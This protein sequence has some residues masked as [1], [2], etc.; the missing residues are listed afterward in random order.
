MD[1]RDHRANGVEEGHIKAILTVAGEGDE[2]DM[3]ISMVYRLEKVNVR[4]PRSLAKIFGTVICIGGAMTMAFFKGPKLLSDINILLDS[5][6][7]ISRWVMGALFLVGSS[8]CWSL[9]LILQV[10]ICKSYVEPLTLSA[11][12]CLLSTL[13]SALLVSFLLPDPAAWRIHSLFELSCCLFAVGVSSLFP[14]LPL[15]SIVMLG[16]IEIVVIVQGVA[17]SGVTFYLQ[18]WCI[19]VRGPL[20][21]AMFNPL[22]TVITT[23][24]ATVIVLGEELHV[25]SLL[26]AICVISGLYVVL[27]GKTGDSKV[28]RASE[29]SQ[30][31]E[32][33]AKES[34]LKLDV[35][36]SIA[37]PL[38]GD[39]SQSTV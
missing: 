35:G 21:S 3:S 23:V 25:G 7:G 11:W 14:G 37:E 39:G 36:N 16:V 4:K 22:C 19:S 31:M 26:G 10:P 8:S 18:S 1:G 24:L 17:G 13:Q 6:A 30:N 27:W 15:Q 20:Y 12:M 34:D 38:L 28:G 32:K 5:S 33:T 2:V 29:Q 9:W